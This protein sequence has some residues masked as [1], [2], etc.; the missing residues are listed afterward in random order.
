MEKSRERR[1]PAGPLL[2]KVR[3][4]LIVV[5][6]ANPHTDIPD[7]ERFVFWRLGSQIVSKLI[8]SSII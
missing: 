6:A 1:G 3:N 7:A 4:T 5:L 2:P 8:N